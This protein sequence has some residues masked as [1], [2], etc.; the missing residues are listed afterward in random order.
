VVHDI[1]ELYT[2]ARHAYKSFDLAVKTGHP[3]FSVRIAKV[4]KFLDL[5][6]TFLYLLHVD[7][8]LKNTNHYLCLSEKSTTKQDYLYQFI[9]NQN[10]L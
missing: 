7:F 8:L 1:Y 9:I 10:I 5:I 6:L 4:I 2:S 3:R